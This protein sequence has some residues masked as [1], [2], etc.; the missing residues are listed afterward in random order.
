MPIHTCDISE[1]IDIHNG[2][3]GKKEEQYYKFKRPFTV[4]GYD[5]TTKTVYQFYGCY[6]H[7]CRKCHPSNEVK[8]D[9]T[10]EQ[11]NLFLGNGLNL[12]EMWE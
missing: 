9:K 4:D 2:K 7:G 1:K 5:K 6:W 12:V 3:V 8:Y 11:R 10:M